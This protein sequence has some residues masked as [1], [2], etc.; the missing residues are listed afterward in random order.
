MRLSIIAARLAAEASTD[1]YISLF[2]ARYWNTPVVVTITTK[3]TMKPTRILV[4]R[5]A[6]RAFMR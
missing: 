5:D 3:T 2:I 4:D 1:W 6:R